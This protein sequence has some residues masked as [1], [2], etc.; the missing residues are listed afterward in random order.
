[1]IQVKSKY[2]P[3][4]ALINTVANMAETMCVNMGVSAGFM[5]TRGGISGNTQRKPT[6]GK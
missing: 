6:Q 1:M 2:L 5:N 4:L 3:D